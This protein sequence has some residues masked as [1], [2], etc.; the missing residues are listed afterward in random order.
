M[1]ERSSE[2][3]VKFAPKLEVHEIKTIKDQ[4]PAY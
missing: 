3:K 2:K 1:I 4:S